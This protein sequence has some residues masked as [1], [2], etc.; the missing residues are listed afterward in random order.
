M[1]T[2]IIV[3]PKEAPRCV[4]GLSVLKFEHPEGVG[5][6]Y[7]RL[8]AGEAVRIGGF[9]LSAFEK[10]EPATLLAERPLALY[11]ESASEWTLMCQ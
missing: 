1:S 8:C 6:L 9:E 5:Q 2:N 4:Y 7:R 11:Q 10:E 3:A